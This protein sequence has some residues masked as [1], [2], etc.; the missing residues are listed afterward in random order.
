MKHFI[1]PVLVFLFVSAANLY[2]QKLVLE[3]SDETWNVAIA[4]F[5]IPDSSGDTIYLKNSLPAFFL[6]SLS[7]CK[8]HTLSEEEITGIRKTIAEKK[9]IEEEKKITDWKKDIDMSFFSKNLDKNELQKNINKSIKTIED[10][11]KYKFDRIEVEP[12]KDILFADNDTVTSVKDKS[13]TQTAPTS[14]TRDFL[15]FEEINIERFATLKNLDYV[16]YGSAWQFKDILTVDIALYSLSEKKDIYSSSVTTTVSTVFESFGKQIT[17]LTSFLLGTN[18]SRLTVYTE[19]N[20]DI[21]L[22]GRYIGTSSVKNIVTTPGQHTITLKGLG[23]EEKIHQLDLEEKKENVIDFLATEFYEDKYIAINTFPQGADIYYDS[24]WRG[25]TPFLLNGLSGEIIVSKDGY[26]RSHFFL[27]DLGEGENMVEVAL[28]PE[29][30][31][32]DD[33][34]KKKRSKFYKNLTFFAI[35]LPIPFF[36]Y[37][38]FGEYRGAYQDAIISGASISELER[39]S[40][41]TNITTYSYYGSIF[42]SAT[43]FV[44]MLFH[45]SDYIKAGDVLETQ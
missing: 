34:L 25:T 18:W 27:E 24:L 8:T 14:R 45:L 21:F 36:I 19:N 37:S 22:D 13:E 23:F 9:I 16:I 4:E 30:F 11:K 29:L 43:L 2:G 1:F 15:T 40:T 31:T 3:D 7:G 12:I 35:S 33:F 10:I 38:L 5:E 39:L 6:N 26:R 28:S 42:L 20:P 32:E 41:L 44:N 17:D